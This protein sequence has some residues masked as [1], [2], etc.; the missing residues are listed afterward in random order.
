RRPKQSLYGL[1]L[2]GHGENPP[3]DPGLRFAGQLFDEESGLFYNRF[4]YYLPE[5]CCYLSADPIGLNGGPNPYAYVHNPANWIDPLGL[6]GCPGTKEISRGDNPYQTRVD[7][8]IPNR[9][10][11]NYSIDT[12]TFTSGKMTANGG[13]RNNKEFWQQWSNLQP[14]SLSKSNMYRIK[15]L[16]L[17]PKIDNQWIKAFPEHVN[18]KG[19]TLIH[20]HV[21]FGHYAIPVP[22]STHVGS[23]GI[24]H[25]K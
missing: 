14:D 24:W 17:S 9:P 21:D 12:S 23:G 13:I 8:R 16:G 4:R 25:T 5:G 10:D 18:Y 20:H 6:A 3:L 1:R 22:S 15:E 7:P 11:P 19:E 2:G